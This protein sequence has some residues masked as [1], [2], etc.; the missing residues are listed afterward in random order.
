MPH[1]KKFF[2]FA[3]G[4]LLRFGHEMRVPSGHFCAAMS[5]QFC[6]HNF[7]IAFFGEV[8]CKSMPQAMEDKPVFILGDIII[9]SKLGNN[10]SKVIIH[11]PERLIGRT[12][13]DKGGTHLLQPFLEDFINRL[14]HGHMPTF[15]IFGFS[16]EKSA[17]FKID[18]ANFKFCDIRKS[19]AALHR[20][21]S[22][23]PGAVVSGFERSKNFFDI[24]LAEIPSL[25]LSTSGIS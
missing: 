21:N 5:E 16:Y 25:A 17:V 7:S 11:I 9:Q 15:T 12:W 8:A 13:E 1:F 14:C 22:H 10:L 6:E 19:E 20:D 18:V 3:C 24:L 23:D 2:Y 4:A